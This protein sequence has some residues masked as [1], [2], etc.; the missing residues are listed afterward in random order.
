MTS[1]SRSA[2]RVRTILLVEDDPQLLHLLCEIVE[3]SG[4]SVLPTKTVRGANDAIAEYGKTVDLL[5]ADYCLPNG[6]GLC[7]VEKAQ[8]TNPA[9]KALL[10]SGYSIENLTEQTHSPTQ[11]A[12]LQK[13]FR[14]EE[15]L[16]AVNKLMH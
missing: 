15:L 16:A 6:S 2:Q 9:I 3:A 1:P 10:L 4:Y 11:I 7:I 5:I 8:L 12:F 13:P 14:I